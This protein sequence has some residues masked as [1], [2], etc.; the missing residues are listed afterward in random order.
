[1]PKVS[2]TLFAGGMAGTEGKAAA[3]PRPEIGC[4]CP[5]S[6][7]VLQLPHLLLSLTL[8]GLLPSAALAQQP[9]KAAPPAATADAQGVAWGPWYVLGPFPHEV[10]SQSVLPEHPP[11]KS[12]KKM[13]A[14]KEYGDLEE[15]YRGVDKARVTWTKLGD[16][17][18]ATVDV[19]LI[20]F[21]TAV[22]APAGVQGWSENA[23]VYLYRE[24][25]APKDQ[26]SH[27]MFGSDDGVRMWLN[28]EAVLTR[29][30]ARGVSVRDEQLRL[31]LQ[32]G[33]NH[34]VF[35]INNGGGAWGFQMAPY[36]HI[37]QKRINGAIDLGVD[38]LLK[39]QHIDGS[40]GEEHG[41]YR[42]GMTA[43]AIYT[44]LKS[45][46][47][48]RHPAILEG[49][50]FLAESPTTRTYSAGCHLMA[51]EALNNEEHLPWME[52]VL[53]DLLS[54]QT[55]QGIWGY[56][57]GHPDL[58]CTQF[59]ALGL[60]AA[61]LA[62]IEIPDRV[63]VDLA[64]GTLDHQAKRERVDT[65]NVL[66]RAY[67]SKL[68]VAGFAY[69]PTNPKNPTASMSAAGIATLGICLEQLGDRCP[70]SLRSTMERQIE[71]G[72]NWLITHWSVSRN[73]GHSHWVHYYLYGVERV[74]AM[75]ETETIG[76]REWYWDGA[77]YLVN[78]QVKDGVNA[79]HW[80][81]PTGRA[82]SATCFALLFLERATQ[83]AF[84]DPHGGQSNKVAKSDAAAAP[85]QVAAMSASPASFWIGGIKAEALGSRRVAEVEYYGREPGGEW[86]LLDAREAP[87]EPRPRE[88]YPGRYPFPKAGR[89]EVR[90]VVYLDDESQLES[91]VAA[92]DVEESTE[93][94]LHG[95]ARDAAKNQ[96][97]A[98]QPEI[99]V[100]SGGGPHHLADNKMVTA[101][102][103]AGND[104]TPQIEFDFKRT[105]KANKLLLTHG[106]TR[107]VDQHNNPR[108]TKIRV[109]INKDDPYTVAVDPNPRAKTEVR[110][111][112]VQDVRMLRIEVLEVTGGELGRAAIGFSEIELQGERKRR[113]R[114]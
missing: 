108:A 83:A 105:V 35:K 25:R 38:W 40:W 95:Y 12:F 28:G 30:S 63:W 75:L 3:S 102:F 98:G 46:V 76:V 44:L 66:E 99:V 86:E 106:R 67:G 91:A 62:G 7:R 104:A 2:L 32:E 84:T 59:A 42:N 65:P 111:A 8:S 11:E 18:P 55:R 50:T 24:V 17:S 51:L 109:T 112:E 81:D 47:P 92:I 73:H 49:L 53:D 114:R 43:L 96:L 21:L 15:D 37:D 56:P 34:L 9:E 64:Q 19:G 89:Y 39:R 79:G 31:E 77:E 41:G 61:A 103:C 87:A 93:A 1:M 16:S 78:S 22:P 14:G 45:D 88:R 85:V 6:L 54:W 72:V 36:A 23:A 26:V 70:G 52:E 113:G 94:G 80:R 101:W 20:N 107:G 71:Y 58:S 13:K 29:N 60:R 33:V 69:R 68:S 5:L 97:P 100:S 4:W 110:F 82:E 10:G 90:A 48:P 57:D 74:G 27:I